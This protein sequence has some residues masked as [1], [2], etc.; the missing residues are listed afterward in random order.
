[1]NYKNPKL[2]VLNESFIINEYSLKQRRLLKHNNE[3]AIKDIQILKAAMS[4]D[5][6][7]LILSDHFAKLWVFNSLTHK[8]LQVLEN[9]H[10][11]E[12]QAIA[13]SYDSKYLATGCPKGDLKVWSISYEANTPK[14]HDII[15][16]KT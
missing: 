1:M 9:C 5:Y 2:L 7:Q 10:E 6:K 3:N 12:I 13:I 4:Y 15:Q 16:K 11:Y 8:L 14:N